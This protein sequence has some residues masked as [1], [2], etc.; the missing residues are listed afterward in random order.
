MPAQSSNV[1][2]EILSKNLAWFLDSW[3]ERQRMARTRRADLI[4]ATIVHLGVDLSAVITKASLADA[5]ALA[6]GRL[7]LKVLPVEQRKRQ[8]AGHGTDS[9]S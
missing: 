3:L 8:E 6:L 5:F 2:S 1:L 7:G 9:D 4:A